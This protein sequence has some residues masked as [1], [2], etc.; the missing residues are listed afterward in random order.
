MTDA[1]TLVPE[2][3]VRDPQ[4]STWEAGPVYYVLDLGNQD[5]IGTIPQL[6]KIVHG[7]FWGSFFEF[8]ETYSDTVTLR[9]L[10]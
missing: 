4:S 7:F 2:Y 9:P 10:H 8:L 3:Y 1:T 6:M 5:F